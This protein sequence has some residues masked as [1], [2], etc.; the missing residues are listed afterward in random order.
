MSSAKRLLRFSVTLVI[1]GLS[2]WFAARRIDLAAIA[3]DMGTIQWF[4]VGPALICSLVALTL[5]GYRWHRVLIREKKFSFSNTFWANGIGY[6]GNNVLPA[7]AG[8]LMR[9]V[10]LALSADIRKSLVLATALTERM[11][12]AGILLALAFVM[13]QFTQALPPSVQNLWSVMMPVVILLLGLA[14][15]APLLQQFWLK[16]I[17]FLPIGTGLK[18]K[19]G[20]FLTGLLDGIR[21]FY[22]VRLMLVFLA[23]TFVIWFIDAAVFSALAGAFGTSLSLPQSVVF[24][25]ALGFASSIPS[26]PG[27]VGVYQAVAVLLLPVFGVS[28]SKAF[29]MVS[30]FQVMF[31]LVTVVIGGAG[32]H[33]M[34]QRIGTNR[35]KHELAAK[36]SGS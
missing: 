7:R 18:Q 2:L 11:L 35:L 19:L 24:V 21:V 10:V 27:F 25:A 17:G 30:F 16:L 33:I 3:A 31:L 20:H 14:F 12:D 1:S 22:H 23:L 36:D 9:S 8:E 34:Q 13:L 28:A 32:W 5:R 26:T 29:L 6:L 15:V 4:W